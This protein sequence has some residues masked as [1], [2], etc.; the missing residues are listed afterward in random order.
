MQFLNWLGSTQGL[1]STLACL[2][3][4][5]AVGWLVLRWSQGYIGYGMMLDYSARTKSVYVASRLLKSPAGRAHVRIFSKLIIYN[6]VPMFFDTKEEFLAAWKKLKPHQVGDVARCQFDIGDNVH[7]VTMAAEM[8][9][10]SI[11]VYGPP[12]P[13]QDDEWRFKR[14]LVVCK[15]TGQ[16]V[17]IVRMSNAVFDRIFR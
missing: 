1:L 11:P 12:L 8:I 17:P 7:N 5:V 16:L 14:G 13:P 2:L 6:D 15:R 4:F 3:I 9:Y 10:G